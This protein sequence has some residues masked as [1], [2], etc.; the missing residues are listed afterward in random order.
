MKKKNT[1]YETERGSRKTRNE[2]K[3]T[4]SPARDPLRVDGAW[5]LV[6]FSVSR[7]WP[8]R[9]DWSR[10]CDSNSRFDT[11]TTA[12]L[13]PKWP[14]LSLGFSLRRSVRVCVFSLTPARLSFNG[15]QPKP[16][17]RDAPSK[18]FSS[19]EMCH[20]GVVGT[21]RSGLRLVASNFAAP[22]P[23]SGPRDGQKKTHPRPWFPF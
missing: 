4:H 16:R 5:P 9:C 12:A 20:L 7:W 6:E 14:P 15:S 1:R 18:S 10:S 11:V 13:L 17:R 2:R 19:L 21:A 8:L 3:K 22:S 23:H